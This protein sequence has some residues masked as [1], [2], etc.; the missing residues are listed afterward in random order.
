MEQPSRAD[1][2]SVAL[3]LTRAM[4]VV[5]VVLLYVAVFRAGA[6]GSHV[7]DA[8]A[9][10]FTSIRHHLH[11]LATPAIKHDSV[12][13]VMVRSASLVQYFGGL[14][15]A[16]PNVTP[17][18]GGQEEIQAGDKEEGDGDKNDHDVVSTGAF[19]S[20]EAAVC[21]LARNAIGLEFI[22]KTMVP[23]LVVA[24]HSEECSEKLS[25]LAGQAS[26]MLR[27]QLSAHRPHF[28]GATTTTTTTTKRV[29]LESGE[30]RQQRR[31][32]DGAD[33]RPCKLTVDD[34]LFALTTETTAV[35]NTRKEKITRREATKSLR[36]RSRA[37]EM[38]ASNQQQPQQRKRRV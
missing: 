5:S 19:S 30:P 34:V 20:A 24:M 12:V 6:G 32:G 3:Y 9:R 25:A 16:L 14:L 13:N 23:T 36:K 4:L 22:Q 10:H 21:W 35:R 7:Q 38:A 37:S 11:A 15:A 29:R 31:R 26:V 8:I 1:A 27:E 17:A 2:V 28:A 18:G 33:E